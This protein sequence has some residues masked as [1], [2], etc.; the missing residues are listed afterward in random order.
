M[1]CDVNTDSLATVE[2]L[3]T[4]IASMQVCKYAVCKR[5]ECHNL[6]PDPPRQVRCEGVG[7]GDVKCGEECEN[8][9][10]ETR[11]LRRVCVCGCVG[12]FVYVCVS[13]WVVG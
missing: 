7:R 13:V 1:G 11:R 3:G 10:L 2:R 12:V 4:V 6:Q 5:V 9:S 8:L